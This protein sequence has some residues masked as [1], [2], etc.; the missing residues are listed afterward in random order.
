MVNTLTPATDRQIDYLTR[1]LER[2]ARVEVVRG[3]NGPEMALA[4]REQVADLIDRRIV[5]SRLDASRMIDRTR[6]WLARQ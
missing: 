4:I 2:R 5:I 3:N 1:L 6:A